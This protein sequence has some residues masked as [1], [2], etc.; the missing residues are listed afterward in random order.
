MP[1][2]SALRVR[3][4]NGQRTVIGYDVERGGIYVDRTKSGDVGFNAELPQCGVRA[5]EAEQRLRHPAGPG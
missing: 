1:T 5:G 4:G 2:S 3:T